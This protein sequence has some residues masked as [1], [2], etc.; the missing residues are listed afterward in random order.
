MKLAEQLALGWSDSGTLP[1]D[2]NI[3]VV[4]ELIR[5]E[6]ASICISEE[7]TY[8]QP[9]QDIEEYFASVQQDSKH[10]KNDNN[11]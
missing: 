6:D 9:K 4:V 7:Q 8:S 2:A 10:Y 1:V 3:D 5:F 11:A